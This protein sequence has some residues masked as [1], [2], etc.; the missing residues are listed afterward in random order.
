MPAKVLICDN[1]DRF[2]LQLQVRFERAGLEV[3]T[4]GGWSEVA[5]TAERERPDA[6]LA[7]LAMPTFDVDELVRVRQV[8][9]D[10]V[11]AV[12]SPAQGNGVQHTA[13]GTGGIDLVF[14]RRDPPDAIV[15]ALVERLS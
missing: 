10:A 12:L 14:S 3:A 13:E 5:P 8:A 1:A 6:I 15:D 9:P 4:C 2:R 11:L 7:D